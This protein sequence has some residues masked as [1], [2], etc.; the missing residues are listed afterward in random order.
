MCENLQINT[1]EL[2]VMLYS[3]LDLFM[4]F[5]DL[6]NPSDLMNDLRLNEMMMMTAM[7]LL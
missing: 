6:G 7:V 4:K 2:L 3:L 5:M 1:Q